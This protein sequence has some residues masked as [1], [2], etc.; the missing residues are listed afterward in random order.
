MI[1]W[2][3]YRCCAV[4]GRARDVVSLGEFLRARKAGIAAADIV[5]FGGRQVAG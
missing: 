1:I 5:F 3:F 4:L 2:R